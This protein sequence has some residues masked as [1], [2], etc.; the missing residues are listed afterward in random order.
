[1]PNMHLTTEQKTFLHDLKSQTADSHQTLEHNQ[2]SLAILDEQVS[3]A[4]YQYY[5]LAL[6]GFV[7][8]CEIQIYPQLQHV[9]NDLDQRNKAYLI[10]NDLIST[11]FPADQ[12][13][14]QVG[15]GFESAA[16]PEALGIMYVLEGSTL[17]GRILYKQVHEKLGCDQNSG[18]SYF[19]GYGAQTGIMWTTFI[20]TL[21]QQ[22]VDGR[23]GQRI[24]DAAN[25]AFKMID[26]RM[27]TANFPDYDKN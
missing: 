14:A 7:E 10:Y 25:A 2:A 12:I 5:L 13:N 20:A 3:L 15:T 22:A 6:Y 11:G 27:T 23:F 18:A 8:A 19:A 9:L 21:S 16:I 26:N 1:M 24:I 17:G 4:Q